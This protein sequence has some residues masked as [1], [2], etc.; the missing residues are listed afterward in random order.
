MFRCRMLS[1]LW[2]DLLLNITSTGHNL[3]DL[4]LL[5]TSMG[6]DYVFFDLKWIDITFSDLRSGYIQYNRFWILLI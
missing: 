4:L 1:D 3:T 2:T 5:V 6:A